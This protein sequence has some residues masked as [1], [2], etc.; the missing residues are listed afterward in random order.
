M[1]LPNFLIIGAP[2]AGTTSLYR[3]L[4]QHPQVF[5][6]PAKEPNFF[7]FGGDAPPDFN[8]PGDR[9][10][11]T[12]LD[13]ETYQRLFANVT[14]ELAAGEA[15]TVYLYSPDAPQR[16]H[17]TIPD[18]KLIAILRNPIDRAFS[19]YLHLRRSQREPLPD[20]GQAL[21]AEA[22]RIANHWKPFWYY[23][24]QGLYG[25]QLQRYLQYF[26]RDQLG[27]WLF[28]DLKNDELGTIRDIFTFLGVD[29]TFQPNTGERVRV[30]PPVP[31]NQ[32]L[33]NLLNRPNPLKAI[34]KS[35][36]PQGLRAQVSAQVNQKNLTKP[37]PTERD[38]AQLIA[39]YRDDIEQL[40]TILHRDLSHW[41]R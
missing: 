11:P 9:D 30:T 24:A 25:Q 12:T 16:I 28:D 41:L 23:Q 14:N 4:R 33:H 26:E 20:F 7:A 32:W 10:E 2:K 15:S 35:I 31:K 19:N 8:G 1:T 29:P 40:Q 38:R 5:M 27:I 22:E 39:A 37:K 17:A 18:A 36:L 13:L 3:Y 21:Q 34:A 6:S